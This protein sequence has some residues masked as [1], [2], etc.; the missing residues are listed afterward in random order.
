MKTVEIYYS[1]TFGKGDSSDTL[2][3]EVEL[4]DEE[5]KLYDE[6]LEND[7]PFDEVDGLNDALLRARDEIEK[8]ELQN[9]ITMQDSY[10]LKCQGLLSMEPY[11]LNKLVKARD[12]H[13]LAYFNLQNATED[14]LNA[15]DAYILEKL[16]LIKEFI[17]DFK[18]YSPFSEGWSLHIGFAEP[19]YDDWDEDDD[20]DYDDDDE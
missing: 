16:P 8:Y 2:D 10:A 17:P 12:S 4:T 1:V 14:E 15:W 20:D 18:P 5:E 6:A 7:T 3:W 13:A 19:D 11:E 9:A